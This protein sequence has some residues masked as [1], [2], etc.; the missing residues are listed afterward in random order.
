MFLEERRNKIL[1]YLDQH[2]RVSVEYL[3]V[4]FFRHQRNHP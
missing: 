3:A 1:D 4:G 2:D